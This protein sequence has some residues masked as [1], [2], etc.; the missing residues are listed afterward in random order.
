MSL[1]YKNLT[2]KFSAPEAKAKAS[3]KKEF[4]PPVTEGVFKN[5]FAL[6]SFLTDLLAGKTVLMAL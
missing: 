3:G 4:S 1:R 6:F 2:I 5:S